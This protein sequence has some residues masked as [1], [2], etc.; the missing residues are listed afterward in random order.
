MLLTVLALLW[1]GPATAIQVSGAGVSPNPFSPNGDGINDT[2]TVSFTLDDTAD[3]VVLDISGAPR[4]AQNSRTLS[5]VGPVGPG[6]VR[7]AW[8]GRNSLGSYVPEGTYSMLLQARRGAAL[9]E[10]V[11]LQ[12][13][14]DLSAPQIVQVDIQ[15]NP[16]APLGGGGSGAATI[17]FGLTQFDT[18]SSGGDQVLVWIGRLPGP[19]R[20]LD[21]TLAVQMDTLRTLATTDTTFFVATWAPDTS[22]FDGVHTVHIEALDRAGNRSGGGLW[23]IDLAWNGP[24]LAYLNL[25]AAKPG[26]TDHRTFLN[27]FPDSIRGTA[28]DRH[29]VDSVTVRYA[30][31]NWI[32]AIL[33]RSSPGGYWAV[34]FPDA[35]SP[36]HVEGQPFTFEIA[37]YGSLGPGYV[38]RDDRALVV[39]TTAPGP[40]RLVNPIPSSVRSA[41]LLLSGTCSG[42]D[43]MITTF[44]AAGA[45][46]VTSTR[47]IP[48]AGVFHDSLTLAVGRNTI[49]LQGKDRAGNFSP[50]L[51]DTVGYLVGVGISAPEVF[52]AGDSFV[53][54]LSRPGAAVEVRI[55]RPAGGF[56]RRLTSTQAIDA[57]GQIFE[58]PWD[59]FNENSVLVGRG[60]YVA[61]FKV[62]YADGTSEV[63]RIAV[64]AMP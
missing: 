13:R 16:L 35:S 60:P 47:I 44:T 15:P 29:G 5:L 20:E 17:R 36:L 61:V 52:H 9:S 33:D 19:G 23:S 14:L 53:A 56:V 63:R 6:Q 27:A 7:I 12:V 31:G 54:Q 46:P 34:P 25:P 38:T 10:V 58:M 8:D 59:L 39:D 2:A 28:T 3:V 55:Y 43:S 18:S 41:R 51:A 40:V 45:S 30:G 62:Q 42:A 11:P 57:L 22:S 49:T 64:V 37:A 4:T 1:A 24:A 50:L 21:D 26:F 48:A 32:T